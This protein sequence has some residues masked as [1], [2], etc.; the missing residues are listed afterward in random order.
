METTVDPEGDSKVFLRPLEAKSLKSN[1][2]ICIL[3]EDIIFP[4]G[5]GLSKILLL[6]LFISY[7][8]GP[9]LVHMKRKMEQEEIQ[10]EESG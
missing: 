3:L 8:Q 6:L 9:F 4:L 7:E 10:V 5:L 1:I 2:C